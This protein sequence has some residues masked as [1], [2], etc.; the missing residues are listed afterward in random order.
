MF[1]DRQVLLAQRRQQLS[2]EDYQLKC[3]LRPA[4]EGTISQF[5]RKLHNGRLMV[6]GLG[7]VRNSVIL[8][9]IGINF[10]RLW[11]YFLENNLG[12]ALLLT[13]TVLLIVF[14]ADNL[15]KKSA[16]L[17]FDFACFHIG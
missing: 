17:D 14:L 12:A 10:G 16:E 3:R 1:S 8:M 4:V 11:A 6:R 9:A 15:G 5:K 7:K 13:L 2:K